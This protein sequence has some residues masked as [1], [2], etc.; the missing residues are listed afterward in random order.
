LAYMAL[1][2]ILNL[3]VVKVDLSA[4]IFI[5]TGFLILIIALLTVFW[6]S[7]HVARKNPSESLRYE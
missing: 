6:Q 5:G 3:F 1:Q 4:F 7:M 2:G